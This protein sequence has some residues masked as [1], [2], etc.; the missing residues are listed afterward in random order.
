LN[1]IINRIDKAVIHRIPSP[2]SSGNL[3]EPIKWEEKR[4]KRIAGIA[5]KKLK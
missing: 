3:C 5:T 4:L 1:K 2:D